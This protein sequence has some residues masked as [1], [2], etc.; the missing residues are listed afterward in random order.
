LIAIASA[1][2]F[3]GGLAVGFIAGIAAAAG[4]LAY[5]ITYKVLP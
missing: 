3:S 5:Y 2:S 4:A 1:L